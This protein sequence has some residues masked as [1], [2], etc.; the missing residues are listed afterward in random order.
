MKNIVIILFI[1]CGIFS[2]GS[3]QSTITLSDNDTN[4]MGIPS[5]SVGL[6][7]TLTILVGDCPVSDGQNF[8]VIESLATFEQIVIDIS[9]T[10]MAEV[11]LP[12]LG[13]Y[14]I[15]CGCPAPIEGLPLTCAPAANITVV[16]AAPIPTIGEWG[17][18]IAGIFILI[19]GVVAMSQSRIRT[20]HRS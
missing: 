4:G 10:M 3:A 6:G 2:L 19:V 17:L 8:I 15:N 7:E 14:V 1:V 9:S 13:E 12:E 11:V 16:D 20:A 18:M 5:G